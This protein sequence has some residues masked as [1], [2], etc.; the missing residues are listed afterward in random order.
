MEKECDLNKN[1]ITI[2]AGTTLY[3]GVSSFCLGLNE[4]TSQ[5]SAASNYWAIP[6][7]AVHRAL[8]DAKLTSI[9]DK[10]GCD[11]AATQDDYAKAHA[12]IF[13]NTKEKGQVYE[14]ITTSP[15]RLVLICE[16]LDRLSKG[17]YAQ[18]L[19]ISIGADRKEYFDGILPKHQ[20]DGYLGT[21]PGAHSLRKDPWEV[22]IRA[23]DQK[24]RSVGKFDEDINVIDYM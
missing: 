14:Y 1:I 9:L 16:C 7:S 17:I 4:A 15:L 11:T 19:N 22:Y 23:P 20:L 2:P 18:G 13:A 24:L 8:A 6:A 10:L 5:L 12:Q 21:D 3:R